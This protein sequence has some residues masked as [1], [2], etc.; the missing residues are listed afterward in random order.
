MLILESYILLFI[1]Y[2]ILFFLTKKLNFLQSEYF[3]KHQKLIGSE[4]IPQI[5]GLIFFI[6]IVINF[7]DFNYYLIL[8]SFFILALGIF[9]DLNYLVS[10]N[11]R[12][13]LQCLIILIFLYFFDYRINDLRIHQF[14][15][16]LSSSYFK[17]IF[18]AF[19]ILILI[20]G[21][22]FIDGSN[23]LNLGYFFLVLLVVQILKIENSIFVDNNIIFISLVAIS[24]LFILNFFNYLYL[25][26][27]G[28]YLLSFVIGTILIYL[29]NIN[30]NISPYFIALLLWYPAF[31]IFFSIVRK[32]INK[33]NP[34]D[35]DTSHLHQLI[36][37][38]LVKKNKILNNYSNQ[39]TSLII[40]LYNL[41]IFSFSIN[42]I[43]KTD[44]MVS[45]I[46][47]NVLVYLSIYYYLFKKLSK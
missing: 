34:I 5:G 33:I 7:S 14:E 23:G 35:P 43:T 29:H 9:S 18:T 28:A 20:N 30:S 32:K 38:F 39:I 15:D 26:D 11:K 40:I 17:Y 4:S 21:S 16:I 1:L 46:I 2:L 8:F 13:L 36:F 41:V 45:L 37:K 47:F 27:S 3:S 12:L 19:C 31:E 22:N 24:F 10:P 44:L 6:F 25:G 42:F